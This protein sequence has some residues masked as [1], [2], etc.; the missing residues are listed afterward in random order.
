MTRM[1]PAVAAGMAPNSSRKAANAATQPWQTVLLL[2][3]WQL[4][5]T[6]C[7]TRDIPDLQHHA[8]PILCGH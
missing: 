6:L 4:R 7:G 2:Q 8:S 5:I 3:A 1:R